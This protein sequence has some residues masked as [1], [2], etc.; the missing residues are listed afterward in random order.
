MFVLLE[1]FFENQF[2]IV[3]S[4]IDE[5]AKIIALNVWCATN[6]ITVSNAPDLNNIGSYCCPN[7]DNYAVFIVTHLNDYEGDPP[8]PTILTKVCDLIWLEVI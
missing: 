7:Q 1:Y 3:T 6:N 2:R 4:S 8:I 5:G